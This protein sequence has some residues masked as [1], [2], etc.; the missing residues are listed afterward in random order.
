M[1][2]LIRVICFLGIPCFMQGQVMMNL[3]SLLRLEKGAKE[4]TAAVELYIQIG[5]QYELREPERSKYYYRKARDLSESLDYPAG[6][7]K[8]I[9]NYSYVLN[10][11]G[12]ADS[13]L[14]LN[15]YGVELSRRTGDSLNLAKTL[16][17]TGTSY[18]FLNEYEKAIPYYMEGYAI[19][20][21]IGD[22][23][24]VAKT[25]DILQVIYQDL[26]QYQKALEYG[27]KAVQKSM[28]SKNPLFLG[29]A[30]LNLGV[31]YFKLSQYEEARH[32]M[33]RALQMGREMNNQQLI[34]SALL[35][36]GS[37]YAA[38]GQYEKLRS[39]YEE[40]LDIGRVT[41]DREVEIT[42]LNGL[43]K[44]HMSV[45]GYETALGYASRAL[46]LA[47]EYDFLKEKAD[48]LEELSNVYFGLRQ[49]SRAP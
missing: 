29:T 11:E 22:A 37:Y 34:S 21:R 15:L 39:I 49:A 31:S 43:A 25:Y 35:G 41:Q 40:S 17:N 48:A 30:Y 36:M 19:F 2:S 32:Y 27:Q 44:Y 1:Y 24:L 6:I 46:S 4:D 10:V 28:E 38:T 5:Q 16:F 3:D 20:D 14:L 42:S 8:Y 26:K 18:R 45:N 13:S 23:G 12:N 9:N 33:E 47:G 7:I